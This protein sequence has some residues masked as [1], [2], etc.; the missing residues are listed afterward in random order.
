MYALHTVRVRMWACVTRPILSAHRTPGDTHLTLRP[1]LHS[2]DASPLSHRRYARPCAGHVGGESLCIHRT[3][4]YYERLTRWRMSP[5]AC[6]HV[7]ASHH[8]TCGDV[9]AAALAM[10][11]MAGAARKEEAA[12]AGR[13]AVEEEAR[14]RRGGGRGGRGRRGRRS[15]KGARWA[16]RR[17]SVR[18]P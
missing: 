12:A 11:G 13:R 8:D 9:A 5:S 7:C 3:P 6:G 18:V 4:C 17:R 15:G 10:E 14:R 1:G 2:C 16:R